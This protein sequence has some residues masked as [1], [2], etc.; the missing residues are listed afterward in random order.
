MPVEAAQDRK[1]GR[2]AKKGAGGVADD[3]ARPCRRSQGRIQAQDPLAT[4]ARFR[5][6]YGSKPIFG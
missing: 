4:T 6:E 1:K 2:A 3:R 5:I